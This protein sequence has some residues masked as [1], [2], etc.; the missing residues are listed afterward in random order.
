MRAVAG[1]GDGAAT[2][3]RATL[4]STQAP[5]LY[6]RI[7]FALL[8]FGAGLATFDG[9]AMLVASIP[10]LS[11]S[12]ADPR[13]ESVTRGLVAIAAAFLASGLIAR[14]LL[15]SR[16]AL[17]PNERTQRDESAVVAGWL[18]LLIATLLLLPFTT[19]Y[20]LAPLRAL[21]T[22][23]IAIAQENHFF[24]GLMQS[25]QIS[26]VVLMPIFAA[27]AV[28][29][30]EVFSALSFLGG[31]LLLLP[32]LLTRSPRFPRAYLACTVLQGSLVFAS[33]YG[34]A[35]AHAVAEWVADGAGST[36]SLRTAELVEVLDAID[37]YNSVMA[38]SSKSLA[39]TLLGYAVWIVPLV[40]SAR[41]RATFGLRQP[42][43][44]AES[45]GSAVERLPSYL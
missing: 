9:G 28:P 45:P 4:T 41:V 1:V 38:A 37:R 18:L 20:E 24:D 23:V 34:A 35:I 6:E 16:S 15:S 32:L 21:W 43:V 26:G 17:L 39:W 12:S 42:V 2:I 5:S 30:L 3:S 29:A 33:I 8:G 25:S 19:F 14:V 7:I 22:D 31:S 27:S 11:F 40:A 44:T 10:T 36:A 13:I